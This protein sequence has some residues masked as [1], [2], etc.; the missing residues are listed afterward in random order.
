VNPTLAA[1]DTAR[2]IMI[3]VRADV[4][5]K[6]IGNCDNVGNDARPP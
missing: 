3:R 1:L 6:A 5:W 4:G 2:L